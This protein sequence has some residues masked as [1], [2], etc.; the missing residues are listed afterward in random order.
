[1]PRLQQV[2]CRDDLRIHWSAAQTQRD[3]RQW[4]TAEG[5][6]WDENKRILNVKKHSIDF[7]DAI[8]VFSDPSAYTYFSQQAVNESRHVTVG[9][10]K[11]VLV[12]VVFTRR[13]GTIRIISARKARRK[14]RELYGRENP[15]QKEQW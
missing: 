15:A 3:L 7:V 5:F 14:E 12:A 8:D 6:G 10:M 13:D 9:R 11:E 1:M 2:L 4:Q